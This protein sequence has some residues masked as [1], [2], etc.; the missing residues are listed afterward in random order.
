MPKNEKIMILRKTKKEKRKQDK[1]K[2]KLD[3]KSKNKKEKRKE[4]YELNN[5]NKLDIQKYENEYDEFNDEELKQNA[6]RLITNM[7]GDNYENFTNIDNKI[8]AIKRVIEKRQYELFKTSPKQNK[9]GIF[10]YYPDLLDPTFNKKIYHKKEFYDNRIILKNKDINELS[11][12]RCNNDSFNLMPTQLFLKNFISKDTPYNGILLWHG[13]GVGKTCS[14]ITIGEQFKNLVKKEGKK[15][16]V[17]LS[18]SIKD[19]FKKQLFDSKK[20]QNLNF[21]KVSDISM[22]LIPQCTGNSYLNELDESI[23]EDSDELNKKVNKVINSY[24]NFMGY[25]AFA[26]YVTKLEEESIRGFD[27]S[28]KEYL[29]KKMRKKMFSDTIF[30]IDEAHHI[31]LSDDNS[32]KIAPPVIERV[33]RDAD[34]VKLILLTATPMY[35][36]QVEII[37]LLNLLLQN[38]NRP[39]IYENDVFD[40]NG[41]LLEGKGKKLSGLDILKRKSTGYISYLRGE[42]PYSFPIRLY[43]DINNDKNLLLTGNM[44]KISMNGNEIKEDLQLKYL[45]LIGSDM[46]LFQYKAY[47]NIVQTLMNIKEP[48]SDDSFSNSSSPK[49][50]SKKT[51]KKNGY[52]EIE[53]GLQI[54]NI[55]FPNKSI[56]DEIDDNSQVFYGQRGFDNSFDSESTKK[57]KKINYKNEVYETFGKFLQCPKENEEKD[58]EYE[59][60]DFS[61]KMDSIL[62]YI[63]NSKGII[64]IYSQFITSGVLPLALALEQNG[65]K[66]YGNNNDQ[67]LN[68]PDYNSKN[69]KCKSEPIS[70]EGK[71]L[72]EYKNKENFKQASYILITGND[73]ISKNN[74]LEIYK[75]TLSNNKNGEQIKIILG[76]PIAG[77]GIDMKRLREVHI[78][79]P[80]HHLNKLEQ[81]I[82]RG[83]RN[84]SHKDLNPKDR[85]CTIFMHVACGCNDA[86]YK[87]EYKRESIDIRVYRKGEQKSIK[88]GIIE[89]ELKKSSVD[90]LINK[91]G[92]VYLEN[93]WDQNINIETSQKTNMVYKIGDKPYSK[94][95]NF[96]E[97]CDY[98]CDFNIKGNLKSSDIDIDTYSNNFA[99]PIIIK[100]IDIIKKMY[101]IDYI[102]D[103]L[104]IVQFVNKKN[105]GIDDKYIYSALDMLLND[106]SIFIFDK[107]KTPGNLIYRGGYYLFQPIK[108]N[109]HN[110]PL[111]Y[112]NKPLSIQNNKISLMNNYHFNEL[113]HRKK[114]LKNTL[115]KKNTSFHEIS[116]DII[117]EVNEKLILFKKDDYWKIEL[118]TDENKVKQILYDYYI[119]RLNY[120]NKLIVLNY[121]TTKLLRK[122]EKIDN[123][124]EIIFKSLQNYILFNDRDYK[125][126]KDDAKQILGFRII[127]TDEEYYCYKNEIKRCNDKESLDFYKLNDIIIDK[128][129][130]S[131]INGY[132]DILQSSDNCVF[133]LVDKTTS[134]TKKSRKSTGAICNQIN[135]KDSIGQLINK[136]TPL[137]FEKFYNKK[138][139][140]YENPVQVNKD[141]L[142]FYLEILLR[143]KDN[144]NDKNLK[145]F[146]RTHHKVE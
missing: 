30:I 93:E 10:S 71:R 8:L 21:K 42:N 2:T 32:N 49:S 14:A 9:Q 76:S 3:N 74:D 41:N 72:S 95:C 79:D 110:I 100:I 44:P 92:N 133:K 122:S 60:K 11:N 104:D 20:I 101:E 139:I 80:W 1:K 48:D 37:W 5:R 18:P 123:E 22:N 70:Y 29:K 36:S 39:I 146:Y 96:Q 4:N 65:F 50:S 45:K 77:E 28:K 31:R 115:N 129:N 13:T 34:N 131:N 135:S 125:K 98:N 117:K 27:D 120:N 90:C 56:K 19:N 142:C 73:S 43:P 86:K 26:N 33:I 138:F 67:L 144:N 107:F 58:G 114:T 105:T 130:V 103:V 126:K 109:N 51:V 132:M 111:Y 84:C 89:K 137:N 145:L 57:G 61:C 12:D 118:E 7:N 106:P 91:Q 85:N 141:Y 6:L 69:T 47:R 54:S 16:F 97:D 35:N 124:E 81:V 53:K 121:L 25:D 63:Y 55:I 64:Y 134:N 94:I 46:S 136:L 99:K 68:L 112:R 59:L 119:D 82:G 17:L 75:S 83:I 88:M 52:S 128:K 113:K 108:T 66:K 15:M 116:S 143:Y 24:Y 102:Y 23:I 87:D 40:S 38:D 78:L 140:N 127:N 62:K